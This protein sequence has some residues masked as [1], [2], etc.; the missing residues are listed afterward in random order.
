MKD[1]YGLDIGYGTA[2][3]VEDLKR[4]IDELRNNGDRRDDFDTFFF[5]EDLGVWADSHYDSESAQVWRV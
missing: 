3:S 5:W 4:Q 1:Y 2:E